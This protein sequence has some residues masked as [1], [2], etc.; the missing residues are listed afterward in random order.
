MEEKVRGVYKSGRYWV[1]EIR[2]NKKKLIERFNTKEEAVIQ[3]KSWEKAKKV[4]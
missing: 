3:R 4:M 2:I 1:A